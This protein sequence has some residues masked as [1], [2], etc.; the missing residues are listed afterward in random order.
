MKAEMFI[1]VTERVRL[2]AVTRLMQFECDGKVQVTFSNAGTKSARQ[3]GLQWRW[4][5]DVAMAGIGGRHEDT[6]EGVHLVSKYHWAVPI[7]IRDDPNF[8]DLWQYWHTKYR[9]NAE[10]ME[11][12]VREKV[13]TEDFNTSQMAEF[14]TE[15]ERHYAPLCS[16]S[17]PEDW[18]LLRSK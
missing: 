9:D 10:R 7:F 3:R 13:H 14:L 16:L 2:N 8:A 6:K 15:F 11:W 4:N 1:L 18:K 17:D 5:T 12:F